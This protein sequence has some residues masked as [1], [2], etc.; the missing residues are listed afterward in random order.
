[1]LASFAFTPQELTRIEA[2]KAFQEFEPSLRARGI[3]LY[4]WQETIDSRYSLILPLSG[5]IGQGFKEFCIATTLLQYSSLSLSQ[6]ALAHLRKEG[7]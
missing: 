3:A 4:I 7:V 2:L 1:M 5:E 6:D